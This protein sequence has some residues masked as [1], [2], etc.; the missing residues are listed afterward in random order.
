MNKD[1]FDAGIGA[2]YDYILFKEGDVLIYDKNKNVMI[3]KLD[4]EY[5]LIEINILSKFLEIPIC[6]KKDDPYVKTIIE[7][8]KKE[9]HL[10]YLRED[11][12]NV[13]IEQRQLKHFVNV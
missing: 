1:I 8:F 12:I 9:K 2:V 5:V 4:N 6:G 10:S 11:I 7:N 3:A 13:D